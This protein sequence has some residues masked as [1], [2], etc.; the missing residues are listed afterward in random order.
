MGK[1]FWAYGSNSYRTEAENS[2]VSDAR[3]LDACVS[4]HIERDCVQ[5]H[6]AGGVGGSFNVH[7]QGFSASCAS[8]MRRNPRPC[9]VC[10]DP[11]DGKLA[12][13]R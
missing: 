7:P 13:C 12:T 4:C 6:G 5:C 8:Q 2:H 1:N 9:F 3:Q 10:H 11:G